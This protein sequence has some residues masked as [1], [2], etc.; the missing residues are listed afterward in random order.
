MKNMKKADKK[1]HDKGVNTETDE[2]GILAWRK[3]KR[4]RVSMDVSMRNDEEK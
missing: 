2:V 4:G 1:K 3:M